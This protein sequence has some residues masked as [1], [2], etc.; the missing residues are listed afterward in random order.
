MVESYKN[1][2]SIDDENYMDRIV[3]FDDLTSYKSIVAKK[4]GIGNIGDFTQDTFRMIIDKNLCKL[5]YLCTKKEEI[6]KEEAIDDLLLCIA[7]KQNRY[8]TQD[9][10]CY[11]LNTGLFFLPQFSYNW[12]N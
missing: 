2:L 12:D 7:G 3:K 4:S 8:I 10:F 9:K 1:F 6:P 11:V 5:N